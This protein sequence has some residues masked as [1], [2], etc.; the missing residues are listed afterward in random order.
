M[1]RPRREVNIFSISALDLFA[2][3]MGAFILIAVILFPYYLKNYEV[4]AE[5]DQARQ[6]LAE[7]RRALVAADER[8]R[9]AEARARDAEAKA[10]AAA[11]ETAR[12]KE[13][14]AE[15][16]RQARETTVLALLGITTRAKSFVVLIDMSG[17]MQAYTQVMFH[18]IERLIEPL[19]QSVRLQIIGFSAPANNVPRLVQWRPGLTLTTLTPQAKRDA[20]AFARGLAQRF[21]GGTPTQT[22]LREALKYP[23]QAIILL[24][25][26]AP[27]DNR[28]D[29]ILDDVTRANGGHMEINTVA[30]G[31]YNKLPALVYFLQTLA[32]RNRGAF[33]G[34]SG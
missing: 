28:I 34:V 10:K 20:I 30:I 9:A 32:K 8:A 2:S 24:S 19:D 1:M 11:D 13:R 25:D 22:A 27:T 6:E 4:V 21:D 29:V 33:T 3:A 12:L 18:T 14:N 15:L 26:G 7:T 17:S 16:E 5:R 31:N 23:A